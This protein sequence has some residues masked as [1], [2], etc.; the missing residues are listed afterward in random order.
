MPN[1]CYNFAVLT[2]PSRKVYEQLLKSIEEN[3]WF[4]TFA[5]LGIDSE[6]FDNSWYYNQAIE[7]WKT[8]WAAKDVEILN[9]NDED[10]VLEIR[11]ETAWSPPT[12]VYSI[13]SKL[14][15]IDVNA[16][17]DE[18][19][20]DFFGRCVYSKEQDI[21]ETFQ[22]PCN[23]KELDELRKILS[24]GLDE[25]MSPTWEHLE[26]RWKE[27]SLEDTE[28]TEDNEGNNEEYEKNEIQCWEW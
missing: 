26:E 19:G 23:K 5:P 11:F 20:C 16:F 1:W 22:F 8:K 14:H 9:Q 28:D 7:I 3:V 10:F 17:F 13:L 18:E 15:G 27:E 21:D 24:R 12:G 25:Y 4:E 2:S 6:I